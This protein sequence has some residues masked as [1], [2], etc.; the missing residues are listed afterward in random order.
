[1][2][3]PTH[4]SE[5]DQRTGT[6][7]DAANKNI[8]PQ[9]AKVLPERERLDVLFVIRHLGFLGGRRNSLL[10]VLLRC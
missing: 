9:N 10:V 1:M 6:K 8:S 4:V 3:E 2:S 5:H 7:E